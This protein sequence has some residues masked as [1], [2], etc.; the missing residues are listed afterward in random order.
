MV[1][2]VEETYFGRYIYNLVYCSLESL[3][4]LK[5]EIQFFK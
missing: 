1:K 3:H 4:F 2:S 5:L